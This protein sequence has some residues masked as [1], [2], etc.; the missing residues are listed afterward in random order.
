MSA[1]LEADDRLTVVLEESVGPIP[2]SAR[3]SEV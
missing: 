1:S 2:P 3:P